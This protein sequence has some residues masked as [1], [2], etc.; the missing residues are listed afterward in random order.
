MP[1]KAIPYVKAVVHLL[2]LAPILYLLQLYRNGTLAANADPVNYITHF[3]GNWALWM[4][5]GSLA[6]TP[7][8]RLHKRL[9]NLIRFRRLLGLYA[10]FYATLHL[11][12]YVFLFSGYDVPAAIDGLRSGHLAEPFHQLHRILPTMIDDIE[13]RRF[14]QIGMLTWTILFALALTSS[15]FILRKMGGKSWQTLH[16][17][18]YGAAICGC[19]HFWWLVKPGVRTPWKDTAVLIVLLAARLFYDALKKRKRPTPKAAAPIAA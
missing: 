11:S 13:K 9:G 8:R 19:I 2:C 4:L 7:I 12:T 18:V 10:F 14:I 5:L 1:T 6:I 3:T 16:R 15:A 17:L